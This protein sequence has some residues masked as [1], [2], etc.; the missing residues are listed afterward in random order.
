MADTP[1]SVLFRPVGPRELKLIEESGYCRFPL[2]LPF[3]PIFYPVLN[4]QYARQIARTWNATK[5][6]TGY[7]GFVTRF[8][9]RADFLEEFEVRTVGGRIHQELWIPAE[10]LDELN[11]AIVG[12]IE[13]TAEYRG[14]PGQ[15]VREIAK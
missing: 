15:E 13:V 12:R 8:S 6:D 5:P 1:V 9:V 14:G 3:Q 11:D 4:E 10:R 2:R 7:R